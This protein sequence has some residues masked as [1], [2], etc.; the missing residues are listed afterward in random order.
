MAYPGDPVIILAYAW[1]DE[2]TAKRMRPVVVRVDENNRITNISGSAEQDFN[3]GDVIP[4]PDRSE[5]AK[6]T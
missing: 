1:V 4:G 2:E 6:S 5:S 3:P